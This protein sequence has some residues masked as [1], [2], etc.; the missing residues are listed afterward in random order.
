MSVPMDI[1]LNIYSPKLNKIVLKDFKG[2]MQKFS[3]CLLTFRA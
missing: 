1:L 2:K 3:F